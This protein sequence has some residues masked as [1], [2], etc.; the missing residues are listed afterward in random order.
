MNCNTTH[1][2]ANSSSVPGDPTTDDIFKRIITWHFFKGDGKYF[3]V[4]WLK[5]RIYRFL[6][7]EDGTDAVGATDQISVTFG[8]NNE[9]TITLLSGMQMAVGGCWPNGCAPNVSPNACPDTVQTVFTAYAPIPLARVFKEAIDTG[10]LE[11]PFQYNVI[12]S[13]PYLGI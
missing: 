8:T 9:L 11:M 5:R 13:V 1:Y 10:A 3:T 2:R 12:V 7:G 4:A 6:Y